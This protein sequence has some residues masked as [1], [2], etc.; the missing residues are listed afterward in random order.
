[1]IFQLQVYGGGNIQSVLAMLNNW[2]LQDLW[3]PFILIFALI[4][5]ILQKVK[6]F[7]KDVPASGTPPNVIAAHQIGDKKINGILAFTISLILAAGHALRYYP[8]NV[9]PFNIIITFIPQSMIA[10]VGLLLVLLLIGF[11]SP[12]TNRTFMNNT[13]VLIFV[14]IAVLAVL[15]S[16]ISGIYPAF[17]PDWIRFN[18]LLQ[19]VVVVIAVMALVIWYITRDDTPTGQGTRET[20]QDWF[21]PD[22]PP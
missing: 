9:D 11:V 19:A 6:I 5:A 22:T 14:V 17:V 16:I 2:G 4:F 7:K 15:T 10:L 21:G 13:L 8:P 3:I 1:M 18:P 20:I 12:T